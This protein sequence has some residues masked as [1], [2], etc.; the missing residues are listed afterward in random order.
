MY[1][2]NSSIVGDFKW[3][4]NIICNFHLWIILHKVLDF[5]ARYHITFEILILT[6][7]WYICFVLDLKHPMP[8]GP[9]GKVGSILVCFPA[10]L[11]DAAR[12]SPHSIPKFHTQSHS[13]SQFTNQKSRQTKEKNSRQQR[14]TP[15]LLPANTASNHWHTPQI[16]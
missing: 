7:P 9:K 11:V 3:I 16:K 12:S 1:I 2:Y 6:V 5:K 14:A 13:H 10:F 15:P 4:F 8:K